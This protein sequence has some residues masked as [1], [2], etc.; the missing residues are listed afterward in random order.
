[1]RAMSPP[2]VPEGLYLY[3]PM[4]ENA[5][6]LSYK[7]ELRLENY[8][9]ATKLKGDDWRFEERRYFRD[10]VIYYRVTRLNEVVISFCTVDHV[11]ADD[12]LTLCRRY[13]NAVR[14]I[15]EVLAEL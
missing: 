11:V 5:L 4:F 6:F 8:G 1:Q 2:F 9:I 13:G 12:V 15:A 10:D 7:N 14:I 3:Q